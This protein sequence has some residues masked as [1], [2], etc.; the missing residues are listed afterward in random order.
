MRARYEFILLIAAQ[1]TLLAL[2][3]RAQEESVD[4]REK[5]SP[6]VTTKSVDE[7]LLQDLDSELL[8]GLEG[9]VLPCHGLE[10]VIPTARTDKNAFEFV[11]SF[12]NTQRVISIFPLP[13]IDQ[14][15]PF[16]HDLV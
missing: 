1:L 11:A 8:E 4:R 16:S 15:V 10:F 7:E 12:L 5:K 9:V 13:V 14:H 6:P 2:P 3:L